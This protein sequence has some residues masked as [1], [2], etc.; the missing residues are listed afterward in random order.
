VINIDTTLHINDTNYKI[1]RFDNTAT[2][3]NKKHNVQVKIHFS[4]DEDHAKDLIDL[5]SKQYLQ[6]D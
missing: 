6:E 2:Y 1:N 3:H 4:K 5:L